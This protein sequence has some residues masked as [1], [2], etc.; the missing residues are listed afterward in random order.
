[1]K[2]NRTKIT[3]EYGGKTYTL[4]YTADALK[5][6][7]RNG[8]KFG[9]ID[10]SILTYAEE[11][12]NGAFIANHSEVPARKR[13]EI[14]AALAGKVEGGEESIGEILLEMVNEAVEDLKPKGNVSWKVER[15]A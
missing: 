7:E 9:K 13:S 1:M 2:D 10:E 14:Y 12:F 11:L 8:F 5:R 3:F 6:M 4:C 15:K